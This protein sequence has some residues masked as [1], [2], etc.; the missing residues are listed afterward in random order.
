MKKFPK[1]SKKKNKTVKKCDATCKASGY[2]IDNERELSLSYAPFGEDNSP[3]QG[4]W[5]GSRAGQDAPIDDKA[6]GFQ[7][8]TP[9]PNFKKKKETESLP[10]DQGDKIK[11]GQ[12][13]PVIINPTMA[14][15][16]NN[17]STKDPDISQKNKVKTQ[18]V[19]ELAKEIL[20]DKLYE[21]RLKN[22]LK[23][24]K[25]NLT[26]HDILVALAQGLAHRF[27]GK[28]KETSVRSKRIGFPKYDKPVRSAPPENRQTPPSE[29]EKAYKRAKAPK[30]NIA[31]DLDKSKENG[32]PVYHHVKHQQQNRGKS[33]AKKLVKAYTEKKPFKDNGDAL[34]NLWGSPKR[35][36]EE[37]K[38]NLIRRILDEANHPNR[39]GMKGKMG[40]RGQDTEN[41]EHPINI[42][43]K[44]VSLGQATLKHRSGET[45]EISSDM[46]HKYL[47][48]YE[49]INKPSEKELFAE[50]MR[51]SRDAMSGYLS[52][53]RVKIAN[54]KKINLGGSK[55][56]GGVGRS[57]DFGDTGNP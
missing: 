40:S 39:V 51:H 30:P 17:V 14:Q 10:K 56:I 47:A 42:M 1:V 31:Y 19:S 29:I 55:L 13:T 34:D 53:K 2:D 21:S 9:K 16:S 7:P 35:E 25:D 4:G 33:A 26:E 6:K 3:N 46:A 45:S 44:A 37:F 22:A 50:H 5:Q 18:T 54:S 12:K 28:K 43:R 36:K 32:E 20:Q 38:L 52:G 41:E 8:K 24:V 57:L 11:L 27:F 15:T 49:S 48:L 23:N